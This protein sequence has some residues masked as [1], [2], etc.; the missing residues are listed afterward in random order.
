MIDPLGL[1]DTPTDQ[2]DYIG[3]QAATYAYQLMRRYG[4]VEYGGRICKCP[5]DNGGSYYVYMMPVRGTEKE[6][7]KGKRSINGH[8]LGGQVDISK[9]PKCPQKCTQVG[10]YHSHPSNP[11]HTRPDD[12][13]AAE[14]DSE[15]SY[16]SAG[17]GGEDPDTVYVYNVFSGKESRI[18]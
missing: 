10:T 8:K 12:L 14:W 11:F 6:D 5:C 17:T 18:K 7:L 13:I 16:V 9:S 4:N 1:K 15:R 2:F 3:I